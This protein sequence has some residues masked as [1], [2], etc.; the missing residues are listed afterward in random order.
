MGGLQAMLTCGRVCG[1]VWTHR[2]EAEGSKSTGCSELTLA[3]YTSSKFI[4]REVKPERQLSSLGIPAYG[5]TRDPHHSLQQ[6]EQY[7]EEAAR[8]ARGSAG[9]GVLPQV[10][11]VRQALVRIA[12]T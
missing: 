3:K 9:W 7:R 8:H 10:D 1:G 11:Q 12:G 4:I 5:Y 6:G 2:E